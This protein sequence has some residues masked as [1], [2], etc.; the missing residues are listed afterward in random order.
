M[1]P[2]PTHWTTA[3]PFLAQVFARIPV[4]FF[5][6]LFL[7]PFSL[8]FTPQPERAF[9]NISLTISCLC[10]KSSSISLFHVKW[11]P[12]PFYL[13]QGSL[14]PSYIYMS[15]PL[16]SLD[17]ATPASLP[18]PARTRQR[19]AQKLSLLSSHWPLGPQFHSLRP[20]LQLTFS[21]SSPL[22]LLSKIVTPSWWCFSPLFFISWYLSLPK[23]QYSLSYRPS[24]F[25]GTLPNYH[26]QILHF[27]KKL[28]VCGN[29]V[30]SD[31][32]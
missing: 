10:L 9:K 18:F 26:L 19:S 4:L 27:F 12:S 25:Y 17:P 8:F 24:S 13:L 3:P 2:R 1:P 22:A 16:N 31:D 29:A 28:K 15:L 14:L 5:L 23:R 21:V 7:P 20:W 11:K 32:G 6:R 30:L